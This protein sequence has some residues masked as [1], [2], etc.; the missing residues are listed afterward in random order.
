MKHTWLDNLRLIAEY[1][2]FKDAPALLGV[3]ARTLTK[4][5]NEETTP[6][7]KHQKNIAAIA[8][9]MRRKQAQVERHERE[10]A[11]RKARRGVRETLRVVGKA[12]VDLPEVLPPFLR[13]F[14]VGR[15]G[16]PVFIYDFRQTPDI[17]VSIEAMRLIMRGDVE[18]DDTVYQ[19]IKRHPVAQ[20]FRFMKSVIPQGTFFFTYKLTTAGIKVEHDGMVFS[21]RA[22]EEL[23]RKHGAKNPITAIMLEVGTA[24]AGA[25]FES[26]PDGIK[27]MG[28]RYI[29]THWEPFC[30]L[31]G[32]GTCLMRTDVEMFKQWY[33]LNDRS[34]RREVIEVGISYPKPTEF[35]EEEKREDRLRGADPVTGLKY[36][37]Q[38]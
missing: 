7:G 20:F 6:S 11:T 18:M 4:W 19:K 14:E 32:P 17:N 1:I 25:K 31:S 28:V 26:L 30:V 37:W 38:D 8:A 34:A 2:Y 35:T 22:I 36:I 23:K 15:T 3:S 29:S 16:S 9:K 33:E 10:E 27:L 12:K 5:V 24:G 21:N 13:Q